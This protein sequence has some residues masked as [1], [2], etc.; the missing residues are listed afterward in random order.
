MQRSLSLPQWPI[1]MTWIPERIQWVQPKLVG[2]V[3]FAEWTQDGEL[4]QTKMSNDLTLFQFPGPVDPA[5][6]YGRASALGVRMRYRPGRIPTSFGRTL[7]ANQRLGS[8]TIRGYHPASALIVWSKL[9]AM[10]KR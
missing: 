7:Q 8:G 10:G 2:E 1:L 3:A 5:A 6:Q 9:S 4:R